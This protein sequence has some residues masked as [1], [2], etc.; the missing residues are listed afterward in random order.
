MADL[1]HLQQ[2]ILS[3]RDERDWQQFHTPRNLASALSI[4]TGELQQ[5][6]LWKTDRE[7]DDFLASKSGHGAVSD[8]IA[9]VA[10]Y[11]I[12]FAAAAGIDLTEA[13]ARKL[14]KNRLKY[15]VDRSK[16]VARKY[17]Q[18]DPE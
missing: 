8:E 17:S 6:L 18:L 5:E 16:G 10:I 11:A 1:Q 2:E 15:P 14:E 13:I 9:D 4:E 7:V 3:F 12:L